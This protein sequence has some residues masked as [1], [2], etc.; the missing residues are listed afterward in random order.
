MLAL[1]MLTEIKTYDGHVSQPLVV[2]DCDDSH[3]TRQVCSEHLPW[4][5]LCYGPR[6]MVASLQSI[7][8]AKN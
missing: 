5:Y 4:Y 7:Q 2:S 3:E 8:G 1:T 6:A